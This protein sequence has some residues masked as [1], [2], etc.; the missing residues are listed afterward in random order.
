M[1]P[2]CRVGCYD[3]EQEFPRELTVEVKLWVD[4]EAAGTNDDLSQAFNYEPVVRRL[5][6]FIEEGSFKLVEAVAEHVARICI[7]EFE[8]PRALVKVTKHESL[9]AM[10]SV[11]IEIDRS[12]APASL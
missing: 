6:Q 7:E 9:P 4:C 11:S 2:R 10:D 12:R 1:R 8:Q 5:L 3:W